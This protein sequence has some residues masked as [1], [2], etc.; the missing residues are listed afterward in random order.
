MPK[1]FKHGQTVFERSSSAIELG[2]QSH[3]LPCTQGV[4]RLE[5]AIRSILDFRGPAGIE[6]PR[7]PDVPI[8]VEH[9]NHDGSGMSLPVRKQVDQSRSSPRSLS[10]P[11]RSL[12]SQ[13]RTQPAAT[14]SQSWCNSADV[15][16]RGFGSG[17][18]RHS[19]AA[20]PQV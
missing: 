14:C 1:S 10:C 16:R 8:K 19:G 17:P 6:H 18:E 7:A 13:L 11:S 15:R 20:G 12:A 2:P 5:K 4:C 9:L 3:G